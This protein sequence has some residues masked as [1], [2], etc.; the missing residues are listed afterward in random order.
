[1]N[2]DRLVFQRMVHSAMPSPMPASRAHR[3]RPEPGDHRAIGEPG[4]DGRGRHPGL[5]ADAGERHL[6]SR[7]WP[8]RAPATAPTRVR[9]R[10][11]R[12]PEQAPGRRRR[13]PPAPPCRC[14]CGA[15]TTQA[16]ECDGH[17][18]QHQQVVAADGVGPDEEAGVERRLDVA[19]EAVGAQ[20]DGDG[21]GDGPE[22]L[23]PG[24]WSRPRRR[25]GCS[26]RS[27]GGRP[28]RRALRSA[29]PTTRPATSASQ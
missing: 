13:P 21:E 27:D 24:R 29:V 8:W 20:A 10:P 22:H 14:R 12:D 5:G 6:A 4:Q 17:E 16:A 28:R 19:D 26:G 18:G 2:A 11:H 7:R 23:G 25:G 9:S 3:E 15:G 1:M